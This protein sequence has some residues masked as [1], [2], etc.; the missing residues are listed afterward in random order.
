MDI[1]LSTPSGATVAIFLCGYFLEIS[2]DPKIFA[3]EDIPTK[4]PNLFA[5]NLTISNASSS[6]TVITLSTIFS[7]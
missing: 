3:L 2:M 5:I 7:S 4:I 6:L 1:Y